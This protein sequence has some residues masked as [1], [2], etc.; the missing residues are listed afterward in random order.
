M[1]GNSFRTGFP[2]AFKRDRPRSSFMTT[3]GGSV[4]SRSIRPSATHDAE[5]APLW[6]IRTPVRHMAPDARRRLGKSLKAKRRYLF[7]SHHDPATAMAWI[8]K[9]WAAPAVR[10][11]PPLDLRRIQD[12]GVASV[13]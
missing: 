13:N 8:A 12:Y 2:Q 1:T 4:K 6:N 3:G 7:E 5:L 11:P 9:I 10:L